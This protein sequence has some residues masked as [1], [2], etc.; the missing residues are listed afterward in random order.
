MSTAN[1][2][3]LRLEGPGA[4]Y[5]RISN[6]QQDT[7]RQYDLIHAFERDHGVTIPEAHWFKDEGWAR[8]TADERPDFQR[9]LRL[10]GRGGVKW[11]VVAE[12]T[13][14]GTEDS[15][16]LIYYLYGLRKAGCRLFTADGKEWT[17]A[18]IAT[19]I[20]AVVEGEKS[21]GEQLTLSH[22]VLTGK[23]PKAKAGDY[24][25]GPPRFGFD[26]V[27]YERKPGGGGAEKW[28]VVTL[29]RYQRVKRTPD[30]REEPYD[31]K[32]NTPRHTRESEQLRLAP[33][34]R[35]DRVEAAVR[36][37]HRYATESVTAGALATWLNDAGFRNAGGG[38][39]AGHHVEALL[40]DPA[41]IAKYAWNRG[42]VG[43]FHRYRDGKP[44]PEAKGTK[45]PRAN[46]EKD[47]TEA[48]LPFEPL[49]DLA[50]WGK[51]QERLAR[52]GAD[53][54]KRAP[55]SAEW[56]L[57]GL[58]YCG[59]CGQRMNA[60]PVR[61]GGRE[62]VCSSYFRAVA[63]R[64]RKRKVQD[65]CPR[66]AVFLEEVLPYLERCLEETGRKVEVL[67]RG[68]DV[69]PLT[70][71][72]EDREENAW[73]EFA[74]GLER[75]KSYLVR[76]CPDQ[77]EALVR[78][79]HEEDATEGEFILGCIEQYN[80][81]FDPG[82]VEAE[83]AELDERHSKLTARWADLP[84]PRAK[85]KAAKELADLEGRIAA[86][87]QQQEDL[88]ELV[89]HYYQE[90]H[91]LGEAIAA[92]RAALTGERDLRVKAAKLRTVLDRIEC[93]FVATGEHGSGPGRKHARL[94]KL[95]FVPNAGDPREYLIPATQETTFANYKEFGGIK[96]AT[97][98]E[99]K[100]DGEKFLEQEIT[101]FKVLDKVDPK[102]FDEPK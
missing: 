15:H 25:G 44:V 73:W 53:K 12:L 2:S 79:S 52:E 31:G 11:I 82:A 96:K 14:F 66:N 71:K 64:T 87:E 24:Q 29:G 13:R 83:R 32:G 23:A 36:L 28:R 58:L 49:V 51:V 38:L 10:A 1:G 99:N 57:S 40:A 17:A 47:W 63:A 91:E 7:K 35:A 86:L 92:A 59:N 70:A 37:F 65:H 56:F 68:E 19:T 93:T 76:H 46:A 84:T 5:I 8:D 18:D 89:E 75:L 4:A 48:P 3:G 95:T 74:L 100:R 69:D 16:Q 50:T 77:Y 102:T 22:R 20:T 30:G 67:A 81:A 27:C 6:D 26:V 54:T 72:L 33:S 41:F 88:A 101:E 45:A 55:V 9:L 21:R 62:Y 94:A 39:F 80:R 85:E 42:H 97:K 43:K 34:C 60:G 90:L 78:D 98:I 61:K